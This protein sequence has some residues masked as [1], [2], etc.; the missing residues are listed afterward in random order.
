MRIA[1]DHL[2]EVITILLQ[3]IG[4]EDK[5]A[6]LVAKILV[7]ADLRG[8]RTH[9]CAFLPLIA[10]RCAHGLLNIPTKTKLITDEG[11]ITHIEGN[12]GLGQVA[13]E[14]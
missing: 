6:R 10:E 7:Q 3:A 4:A 14:R 11:A 13:A 9:G 5:E 1:V 8:I 12:N 2:M